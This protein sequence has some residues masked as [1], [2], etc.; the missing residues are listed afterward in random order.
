M[1]SAMI[2]AAGLGKRLWPLTQSTPKPLLQVQGRPLIEHHVLRLTQAGFS[3]LVINVSHLGEQIKAH[4]G[5][6]RRF[7]NRIVYSEEELPLETAGGIIQAL[8]LLGETPFLV[9]SADIFTDFPIEKL[10]SIHPD[11]AHLIL[12]QNPDWHPKGDFGLS[13][14]GRLL[15]QQDEFSPILLPISAFTTLNFFKRNPRV[16]WL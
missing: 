11:W 16:F 9:I 1:P 8:P 6:G 4:L 10:L 5:D 7:S 14:T 12:M 13:E 3:P 2:L 15:Y